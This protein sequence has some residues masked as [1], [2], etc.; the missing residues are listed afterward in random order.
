[1]L[2]R[3]IYN[4][5]W[6]PYSFLLSFKEAKL[7][8]EE[9]RRK[10]LAAQAALHQQEQPP[11]QRVKI[12]MS[13]TGNSVSSLAYFN[14]EGPVNQAVLMAAQQVEEAVASKVHDTSPL[15]QLISRILDES[16]GKGGNERE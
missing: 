8:A 9:V 2:N 6:V 15:G 3:E 1:M 4:F 12:G 11:L 5:P 16:C 13:R 14:K 7:R 10:K